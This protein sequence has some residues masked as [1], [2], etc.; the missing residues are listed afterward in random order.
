M[1]K[2]MMGSPGMGRGTGRMAGPLGSPGMNPKLGRAGQMKPAAA[3]KGRKLG[4][5]D[6]GYAKKGSKKRGK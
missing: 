4:F 6:G 3:T 5:A 2:P 1:R